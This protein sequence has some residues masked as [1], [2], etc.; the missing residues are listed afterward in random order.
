MIQSGEGA[1]KLGMK[2][3]LR[4]A[5]Q[6]EETLIPLSSLASTNKKGTTHT[7]SDSIFGVSSNH[8]NERQQPTASAQWFNS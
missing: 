5:L 4:C 6:E 7:S 3:S 2:V 1:A 8:L